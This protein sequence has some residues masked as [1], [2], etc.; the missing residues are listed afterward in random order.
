VPIRLQSL[1]VRRELSMDSVSGSCRV[2]NERKDAG[3][4]D[5]P[6]ALAA[7]C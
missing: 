2:D 4:E 3:T 7:S 6:R 5:R 1:T